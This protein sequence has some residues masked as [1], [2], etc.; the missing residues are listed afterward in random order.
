MGYFVEEFFGHDK[1]VLRVEKKEIN[2]RYEEL[3]DTKKQQ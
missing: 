3:V 1:K 2:K